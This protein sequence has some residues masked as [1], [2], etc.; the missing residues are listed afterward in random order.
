MFWK[1]KGASEKSY[2]RLPRKN[3]IRERRLI[4]EPF[5]MSDNSYQIGS[6]DDN[7]D[8]LPSSFNKKSKRSKSEHIIV[9]FDRSLN[10]LNRNWNNLMFNKNNNQETTESKMEGLVCCRV[11]LAFTMFILVAGFTV[12]SI[13]FMV[14]IDKQTERT[15]D[16]C[17]M[18]NCERGVVN[19]ANNVTRIAMM[20]MKEKRMHDQTDDVM[21]VLRKLIQSLREA[22]DMERDEEE[23][24]AIAQRI[25]GVL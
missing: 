1:Q 20:K 22:N 16:K 18:T 23:E 17:K 14:K 4:E 11:F 7:Y 15:V 10:N 13:T 3:Q 12:V 24:E 8:D 19:T 5:T 25:F 21:P 9:R 2:L 6:G